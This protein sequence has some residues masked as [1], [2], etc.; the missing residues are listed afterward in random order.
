MRISIE[1]RGAF[2][3][4]LVHLDAGES[5]V[6]ESGAMYRTSAEIDVDVTTRSKGKGGIFSGLKRLLGGESFFLSNEAK[7]T[8]L[9][10]IRGD[11]SQKLIIA[12]SNRH[13]YT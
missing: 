8:W 7:P 12:K 9:I 11:L 4:A 6:S 10:E 3:S 13:S 1:D 5:F 2:A